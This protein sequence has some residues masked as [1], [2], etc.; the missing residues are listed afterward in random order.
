GVIRAKTAG[1]ATIT[2]KAKRF[3][4]EKTATA[5]IT[6][7]PLP[8]EENFPEVIGAYFTTDHTYVG[9][10]NSIVV[11]DLTGRK[12]GGGVTYAY[13]IAD[14]SIISETGGT[15]TGHKIGRTTVKVSATLDGVTRTAEVPAVV[16]G[17]N[18]LIRKGV[19][20]GE[21][22]NGIYLNDGS[23]DT[24]KDSSFWTGAHTAARGL[25]T[26][27]LSR[28]QFSGIAGAP[29]SP[30]NIVKFTMPDG[31]T[32]DK[33]K[34]VRIQGSAD[35]YN[36]AGTKHTGVVVVD[37]N[38]LYEFSGY[39]KA[40]NTNPLPENACGSLAYLSG[41]GSSA[42]ELKG[43]KATPWV[44]KTGDQDWTKFNVAPVVMNW[45]S[46]KMYAL[47]PGFEALTDDQNHGYELYVAHL[48][49]HEVVFDSIAFSASGDF[50]KAKTYD[51][52]ATTA[53][54]LSNTGAEIAV[55]NVNVPIKITYI[56]DD[57]SIARISEDG[58]ITAVSDG[59][60]YVRACA[61]VL[62][63]S[64]E[65]KIEVSFQGLEVMFDHVDVS[66]DTELNVGDTVQIDA[67]LRNTDNTQFTGDA[68]VYF[69]SSDTAVARVSQDGV[70]TAAKSGVADIN[71]YGILGSRRVKTTVSVTVNDTTP[72]KTVTI[73]G[74]DTVEKGF[75]IKLSV[76]A[77]HESGS[78]AD[79]SSADVKFELTPDV[80][81]SI[82]S[83]SE[84]GTVTGKA[85]GEASVIATVT[86]KNGS[87]KT[88]E[89]F[90]VT[91]APQSPQSKVF[92][93][94]KYPLNTSVLNQTIENDGFEINR[95]LSSPGILSGV[96]N[97]CRYLAFGISSVVSATGN[98][99]NADTVLD[100][101]IDYDG[102]YE[103]DFKG[104]LNHS[105]A[106]LAYIYMDG[107]YLGEYRF[108]DPVD[109]ADV[110]AVSLNTIYLDARVHQLTIRSITSGDPA[111]ASHTRSHTVSGITFR[112]LDEIPE[113]CDPV[114][115]AERYELAVG[116]S[117]DLAVE[118]P[119]S[120]GRVHSFG[121]RHG[122]KVDTESNLS[123]ASE[124]SSVVEYKD[125]RITAKAQGQATITANALVYKKT[126]QST[127]DITVTD[128]KLTRVENL[129]ASEI[130]LYV[131]DCA[132][133][134]LR[135]FVEGSKTPEREIAVEN[136]KFSYELLG[137]N[138][139]DVAGGR[140]TATAVG[141]ATLA[142]TAKLGDADPV[143]SYIPV[144][145]L[146]DGFASATLGAVTQVIKYGGEGTDI[147]IKAYDNFGKEVDSSAAEIVYTVVS[148]GDII[149]VDEK[150]RVLP[151]A[152]GV[153]EVYATVTIGDITHTTNKLSLSVRT[154]KVGSTYYT[155]ERVAAARE[156]IQKYAW[157]KAEAKAV[158]EKADKYLQNVEYIYNMI[159]NHT[160]PRS[161]Y[162][163]EVD[164]LVNGLCMYCGTDL[165]HEYGGK[166]SWNVDGIQKPWKVQ[167]AECK[168]YFPSNDFGSFY[169]LGLD[170]HGE[171]NR[172]LALENNGILCGRGERNEDGEYVVFEEYADNPYGYGDMKGNLWNEGFNELRT[173]GIDP[174]KKIPIT[175]GWISE[176]AAEKEGIGNFWGV[177][178]GLGYDT[179]RTH[180]NGVKEIHRYI[181]LFNYMGIW[182]CHGA[183]DQPLVY[184]SLTSFRDAY[185]YTGE[186][187]YGI[188]G[189]IILDRVA[190]LYPDF[191]Y[192]V[193]CENLVTSG[194]GRGKI[195]GYI[196]ENFVNRPFTTGYDAFFD[197]YDEPQVIEF[198]SRY[199]EKWNLDNKKTNGELIRQNAEENILMETYYATARGWIRGNFGMKQETVTKAAT[200]LDREPETSEMIDFV[201]RSGILVEGLC[202]GCNLY[203]GI[204]ND[205]DRDGSGNEG[206]LSYNGIFAGSFVE[207]INTLSYYGKIKGKYDLINNPKVIASLT[208]GAD[209]I[210]AG[211]RHANIGDMS[212]GFGVP[213][214]NSYQTNWLLG[215]KETDNPLFAQL[216]YFA[217]GNS[218][219]GI[220]YDIFTKNPFSPESEIKSIIETYGELDLSKSDIAT[221]YGFAALRDG[222][223]YNDVTLATRENT[224]RDWWM[225]FGVGKSTTHKHMDAL[226]LGIDAFGLNMAPDHGYGGSG[227]T[228]NQGNNTEYWF[229]GTPSHNTVMVNDTQQTRYGYSFPLHFDD[230]G[231]V[232]VMDVD[233]AQVY[234][235]VTDIYRRTVVSVDIDDTVSYALDFFRIKGGDEHLY[236]FHSQSEES[237][238]SGVD[239]VRQPHGSYAG[240]D[241]EPADIFYTGTDGFNMLKNV[242]RAVYPEKK[243]FSIDFKI[244]DY[245]K[246]LSKNKNLHL[247][248]T[249]LNDFNVSEVVRADGFCI[250]EARNPETTDYL[251]VRRSGKN[252]D[253]LFTSVIEPYEDESKIISLERV[254]V[255]RKDGKDILESDAVAAVKVVLANGRCDYVVYSA[256]NDVEYRVDDLFDFTGF[257]GVYSI[258]ANSKKVVGT[259]INDGTKIGDTTQPRAAVSGEVVNFTDYLNDDEGEPILDNYLEITA[260]DDV[261]PQSLIGRMILIDND[262]SQNAA[263]VIRSAKR[264]GNNIVLGTGDVNFFRSLSE[265]EESFVWNIAR[266][267]G[268]EIPMSTLTSAAPKISVT[269]THTATVG[270]ATNIP[271]NV[272]SDEAYTLV[273][274]TLPGGMR[275]ENDM[276]VWKPSASQIGNNHVAVTV[277]SG[278]LSDTVHFTVH[279][280]GSTT[281]AEAGNNSA[282]SNE[283][284]GTSSGGGAGGGGAAPAPDTGDDTN[285]PTDSEDSYGG[286]GVPDIHSKGFTD[287]ASHPWAIDAINELAEEGIIKGTSDTTFSPASN[288]TR[289]DFALLLVRAFKLS[290]DNTENFADV[291]ESDYFAAE[292]AI[293]RNCGIV[294]GIGDNKY[295]PRNHI[296]RQDMMVIVYRALQILGKL[297]SPRGKGGPL[298][299]DEVKTIYHDFDTVAEYAK[300]AVAFLI[301]EGLVNG[302]SGNIAPTDYTTRAEV[303]VLIKRILDYIAQ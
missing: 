8:Q 189:A 67:V 99:K 218:A 131:G 121:K 205:I 221:G 42:T 261:E 277:K 148:D 16:V 54:L 7:L 83:V 219:K 1:E 144:T 93:F 122:E 269:G 216:L 240:I 91:V 246:V 215:M 162:L 102:W 82:L 278:I 28:N 134:E 97:S 47:R 21:L 281:G 150:G 62:G 136:L 276:L 206:S 180:S 217:N 19:N 196:H 79:M 286:E 85:I 115:T 248:L 94:T 260:P 48:S 145:V 126:S 51:T 193:D 137:D 287:L 58:V 71:V 163:E 181:A 279:V 222:V 199:A 111:N 158:I 230:A 43:Y 128:E 257:V 250:E 290:S 49:L 104:A 63:V 24:Q 285:I 251:L 191:N 13:E 72:L 56:S 152:E 18:L 88:S 78:A 203:S 188:A 167:C 17:S 267:Q 232:K 282:G 213:S 84:D 23:T 87:S 235:D 244:T 73:S 142:V 29:T 20:H 135:A 156:N 202:T 44:G 118:V 292:L 155:P 237:T 100:I 186:K 224:M 76:D 39:I 165:Y 4:L 108:Y 114:I 133:I 32:T 81:E 263:Y 195:S 176:E 208:L 110:P 139:A 236:S 57:E 22:E 80:D 179:G 38:K 164:A 283:S 280:Y 220:R 255:A 204:M 161:V 245:Q 149:S 172:T 183:Y 130:S 291:V 132:D 242:E 119:L 143:T 270:S 259:Y 210:L 59:K 168:R 45:P 147:F 302:K 288:I 194:N 26:Y 69:E 264:E 178:D 171:F 14:E 284:N 40:D 105:G 274:A 90:L 120:N 252:L 298:A 101:K 106:G 300:E 109:Q 299:V 184:A 98:T 92:D 293:A 95:D 60:T 256:R 55:G 53:T 241:V 211:I 50:S 214:F 64:Q 140:I 12:L 89:P 234:P 61:T 117:V 275:I 33:I 231:N 159:T 296:T 10:E 141:S 192:G 66:V 294:G 174:W 123:I 151:V 187:K 198:L 9:G 2:V 127:A 243:E 35:T 74:A 175:Q 212:S 295:A 273:G 169:E 96:L 86:A 146:A 34:L 103:I 15:F 201:M 30:T 229:E 36:E 271:I 52:F 247:K 124:P 166:N 3:G 265:D 258:D 65:A 112:Y 6:V 289:A 113:L 31:E 75:A 37:E 107:V 249:Q 190:D 11:T 41:S 238:V 70:L 209:T 116:E 266:G 207:V 129:S 226:N 233:A 227:G 125:G 153:A 157:A 254:P 154:G 5:Q 182:Y 197:C 297:P 225:F 46:V 272:E 200:I 185:L 303:A 177:D 173:S 223:L 262:G 268:Y 77:L 25:F 138:V 239:L 68:E 228:A 301:S 253:T 170:E 27:E 160:I